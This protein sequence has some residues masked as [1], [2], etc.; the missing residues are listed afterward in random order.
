[1]K[2]T[3][4][5]GAPT[6][7]QD[8][9]ALQPVHFN[10]VV[11]FAADQQFADVISSFSAPLN[12]R[13]VIETPLD[14]FFYAISDD[15]AGTA[16]LHRIGTSGAGSVNAL[17]VAL[18]QGFL[19]VLR[20]IPRPDLFYAIASDSTGLSTLYSIDLNANKTNPLFDLGFGFNNAGLTLGAA[21]IPEPASGLLVGLAFLAFTAGR[22]RWILR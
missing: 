9:A 3:A 20:S 11:T 21:A 18:G 1:M 5:K 10:A 16:T 13:L 6:K 22:V 4:E 7:D 17:P 14:S 15:L 2:N 12:K 19:G 8:N